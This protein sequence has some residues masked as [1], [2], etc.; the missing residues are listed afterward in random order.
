[1]WRRSHSTC[2]QEAHV[3]HAVGFVDDHDLE[4]VELDL[5]AVDEV[6][7]A[8]GGGDDRL[9]AVGEGLDLL[10]HVG[11]AVDGDHP[12]ADGVGQRGEHVVHLERELAGGHEHEAAGLAGLGLVEPLEEREAE[13]EGL[14]RAGLGLA[15][16]V[17][18]RRARR[19]S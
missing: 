19:R 7:Q 15:A 13:G 5:L 1:M 16:H 3:G 14:A 8:A 10:V 18:A 11:P 6:D 17:A 12:A 4:A 9:D 2:G